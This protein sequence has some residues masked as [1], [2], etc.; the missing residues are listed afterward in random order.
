MKTPANIV[1]VMFLALFA[2][3]TI[4]ACEGTSLENNESDAAESPARL[5]STN[6]SPPS[7]IRQGLLLRPKPKQAESA[8]DVN[9][10]LTQRCHGCTG[11]QIKYA[12]SATMRGTVD[13]TDWGTEVRK[14]ISAAS[15]ADEYPAAMSDIAKA[16]TLVSDDLQRQILENREIEFSL[17]FGKHEAAAKLLQKTTAQATLVEPLLSDRLFWRAYL[18]VENATTKTWRAQINPL[19]EQALKADTTSFQVRVW[20]LFGWFGARQWVLESGCTAAIRK[21]SDLLL[22]T[23]E[24]SVCPLM[25]GHLS[26]ALE[27]QVQMTHESGF[28]GEDSVWFSFAQ[29]LLALFAGNTALGLQIRDDI[30][31]GVTNSNCR[32]ELVG[33]IDAVERGAL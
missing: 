3:K 14:L 8:I 9:R 26:H 16:K 29:S 18:Q 22:D 17:Q 30:N 25:L 33:A 31:Q 12:S 19:L 5:S 27:R 7:M 11:D 6:D 15:L 2:C 32:A 4:A 10:V 1:L 28:Q 13:V 23:T 20:R 21:F 24:Q